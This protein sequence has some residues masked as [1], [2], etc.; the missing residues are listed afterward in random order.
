MDIF[1]WTDRY[2]S[3]AYVYKVAKINTKEEADVIIREFKEALTGRKIVLW[4]AGTVGHVFYHML[5]ELEIP[6]DCIV[7]RIGN[8]IAFSD[9]RVVLPADSAECREKL[10]DALIIVTVNRN[11]YDEVKRDI[12]N[13]GAD[14]R[15]ITCGH[16]MHM[17]AQGAYCMQKACED[18]RKIEIKNCYEC[19]NLDNTCVSLSRY[20]KRVNGFCDTGKG[21]GAVRMIG[22]ALSNICTL[23]CKNC[24][25]SVPY[26]PLDSR[27]FVPWENVVKD[28]QK[29]S[30]ACNFLTLLEFVGGEPFLHPDFSRI[31]SKVKKI[32]NIG[33]IHVF[34]NGTV[35]PD[36]GLCSELANDRITVYLSNYQAVL[37]ERF[38]NKI[39]ETERKLKEYEI[40]YFYG[41]KQNWMDFSQY[42]LV[43]MDSE[44]KQV[45][46]EC[47]LHNCNRLQDGTLYVCAHQYA[48][49]K[50]RK[51]E[52]SG[53]TIEIH[54]YTEQEL[55]KSWRR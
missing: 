41:K 24:C 46:E 25:E 26:M 13:A 35:I 53:E 42:D 27:R 48:G 16:D 32:K 55:E 34:T 10:K 2:A 15:Q 54:N 40:N 11:I 3:Q 43:N 6:V 37:P 5:H 8:G 20:L 14:E 4:G 51:L 33:I 52:E 22:Y 45:F 38:L 12:L 23:K 28:I 19:T 30:G 7:D 49:I 1:E 44:L 36:D 21:T 29:V 18:G 9:G 17:V 50:L 31:L 47:F 39:K